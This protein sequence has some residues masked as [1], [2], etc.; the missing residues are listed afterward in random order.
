MLVGCASGGGRPSP[1]IAEQPAESEP[2]GQWLYRAELDSGEG[3]GSMR[4]TLRQFSETEFELA[5]SDLLGEQRW[6]ILAGASEALL[7]DPQGGRF[8]R[9][10]RSLPLMVRGFP[11]PLPLED[12]PRLLRRLLPG[13]AGGEEATITGGRAGWIDR[14]GRRWT[15]ERSQGR[16]SRWTLWQEGRPVLWFRGETE[17]ATLSGREPAFQLRWR[18]TAREDLAA[19]QQLD[20]SAA[21]GYEEESCLEPAAP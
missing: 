15:G 4:L 3:H 19:T 16:W 2:R 9:A 8:C 11:S 10:N 20:L 13:P 6:R 7:L 12:L 14:A 1:T 18:E 5:A 17:E 21:A